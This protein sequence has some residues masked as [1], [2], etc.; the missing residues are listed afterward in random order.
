MSHDTRRSPIVIFAGLIGL[1]LVAA[2]ITRTSNAAFS[3]TTDNTG[4]SFSA[5][6]IT[7]TDDDS[8][9]AMF[10]VSDMVPGDT[11]TA[12]IQVTYTG[13]VASP[14]VVKLYSGGYTDVPGADPGSD[15]LSDDL[16]VTV[17]QGTGATFGGSC[18]GFGSATTIVA[19]TKLATLDTTYTDYASGA[20]TW[21]PSAS[22]QSRSYKFTVQL[23][24]ATTD[25]EQGA[26]TTDVAFVWEIQS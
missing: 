20:G 4:N 18:A 9:T 12:C 2:L 7:L 25:A 24:P 10:T 11:Q 22:P 14:G 16:N 5:G 15:G 1:A 6:A 26:S 21:T 13:T 3:A 19:T 17:E 23:D 8:T